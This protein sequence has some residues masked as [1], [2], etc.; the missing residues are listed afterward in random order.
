MIKPELKN[1]PMS[2][3]EF[4][5]RMGMLY[6]FYPAATGKWSDDCPNPK[7]FPKNKLEK[8]LNHGS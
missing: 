5:D 3:Y 8:L 6:E 2:A 7:P 1:L 4:L